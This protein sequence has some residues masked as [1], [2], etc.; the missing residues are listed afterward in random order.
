MSGKPPRT[1]RAGAKRRQTPEAGSGGQSVDQTGSGGPGSETKSRSLTYNRNGN[2]D[3]FLHH[4]PTGETFQLTSDS[5]DQFLTDVSGNVAVFHDSRFGVDLNVWKLEFEIISADPVDLVV[6]LIDTVLALNLQQ[7]IANGL[8]AKLDAV[9]QALGD[10]NENNDVAA[11]NALQ[12]FINAVEAQSG[13]H[14][15]VEDAIALIAA[16]QEIIDLLTGG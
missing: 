5:S 13:K 3:I 9:F 11:V 14:I 7:G 12:A 2:R 10:L 15:P 4:L 1:D 6:D 8:D 16:A